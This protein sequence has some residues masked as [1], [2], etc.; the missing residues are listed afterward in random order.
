M[1]RLLLLTSCFVMG[2]AI[3]QPLQYGVAFGQ[4]LE[5]VKAILS[6]RNF[7]L[8]E[9]QPKYGRFKLTAV[10]SVNGATISV[11]FAFVSNA[12]RSV[13]LRSGVVSPT[14]GDFR[15]EA[16][17]VT[18]AA[19]ALSEQLRELYGEPLGS[20][21]YES[22]KD[23]C[24]INKGRFIIFQ[25]TIFRHEVY[26]NNTGKSE[27]KDMNGTT[28]G[29]SVDF[30]SLRDALTGKYNR[31]GYQNFWSPECVNVGKEHFD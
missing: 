25:Q 20:G 21:T 12:L 24:Y 5:E 7:S 1:F 4:S 16:R 29:F 30:H 3:A 17:V 22:K 26:S 14:R 27:F 15:S 10:G 9:S 2:Q 28:V 23:F 6:A 19:Q 11:D 8:T 31:D 18:S 13:H